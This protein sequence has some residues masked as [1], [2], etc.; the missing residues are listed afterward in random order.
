MATLID[1][2]LSGDLTTTHPIYPG[3]NNGGVG[4]QTSYYLYGNTSS[5]GIRTNGNFLV[6]GNIYFGWAGQWLSSW[7]NQNVRTDSSP[8]FVNVYATDWFR[9]YNTNGLYNQTYATHFYASSGTQWNIATGSNIYLALRTGHESTV[10]GYL[11]ANTD[12]NSGLLSSDGSW[13]VRVNNSEVELYHVTYADDF[14]PNIIYDRNNTSYY[15]N[16]DGTSNLWKLYVNAKYSLFGS[17]SNWDSGSLNGTNDTIT[18]V[19]FQGHTDFWIGAGNTKW[20]TGVVSGHHDLLINTMQSSGSNTRGITFTASLSG[21]SVYRLGRWFANTTQATSYLQVDGSIKIGATSDYYS[22]PVAK[23]H[24]TGATSGADVLAIDGVN[25]RLFTVTD[26]LS[27][28]LF[29]VNTVAGLPVMEVFADNSIVLG[30]FGVSD[31]GTTYAN[32]TI[33]VK[34]KEN[35]YGISIIGDYMAGMSFYANKDDG[36]YASQNARLGW[37]GIY[38]GNLWF[39]SAAPAQYSAPQHYFDGPVYAS[40]IYDSND[41]GYYVNPNSTSRLGTVNANELRSYGNT[42][43]G[44][45]S[46]DETHINDIVR[47]GATDSG[48]AHLFFGEGGAAGSDYGAHWYW[49]SGYTFTWNTRN[50]GSDTALFTYVT[51]DTTYV[52]WFRHFNMGGKELN[53]V[54]QVHF[55]SDGPIL[56]RNNS[57]NLVVKGGTS[58]DVGIVGLDASG[59][60]RFQ[61]YG[62]GNDYGFLDGTW[63][64]WDLRKVKDGNLYMNDNNTYYLNTSSTSYLYQLSVNQ[65]LYLDN[66]YGSSIVGLY[67]SY[68]YQGVFAMGNSYKLALD[69]TSPGSLYGLAWTHTNVGGESK[70]GLSHQLLIMHNGSTQTAIGTGIWT[71]GTITTTS[72]GTSANWNTAYGWGNHASAGYA[73]SGHNHDGSYLPIGGKAADSNLLDGLDLHTGRNNEAN[74]VVRTDSDGYI[75]AGW[76][77]TTSGNASTGTPDKFFGSNDN[78]IRYYDRAY[79]QMY[80]GNTYKYTTSRRQHTTDANYW[81]GTMGWGTTDWN[82]IIDWGSGFVESWSN[83]GNQPASG[84]S[85]HTGLQ[86]VHYTNGASRY[87]WQMVNAPTNGEL[88]FRSIWG[89]SFTGW[90]TVIHSS[91]IGSQSVSY[92]STSGTANTANSVSWGNVTGKPSTFTP[93]SHTHSPTEVGLGNVT[94]DAQV[95]TT[96]NTS[97]NSDT[98]NSRGV[99]RLYRYDDNSD[100]SLQ[101]YWTGSYW[102]LRGF[103]GDTYHAGVQ[104]AYADS[105]GSASSATNATTAGQVA[106]NYNNDSN[107]TYQMLWGSGNSVYGTGGIYCNP[108]SDKIFATAFSDTDTSYYLDPNSYSNLYTARAY[109]WQLHAGAGYGV[110]FWGGSGSYSIQMSEA[111]NGS[112]G[113][114]VGGETTSDYNMYF[115]MT[116]GTNRGFVFRNSISSSGAVAGIDG[117]GNFRA[118]GDAIVYASSDA[119]LK[120][121]VKPIENALDKVMQ[122]RGVEFDWNNNQDVYTGHD[123]GVIA[124]EVEAVLP[125]IVTTRDTGY[126]AVK[127]EKLTALLIE[128]VKELKAEIEELKAQ[129]NSK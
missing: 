72:H 87:G 127:Y 28:S 27:D 19:H 105:A 23:L 12:N 103:N 38:Q 6:D 79:T 35:D 89:S 14:R 122:L 65:N 2:S 64:A 32:G 107:S 99:T 24:V 18:N 50:A 31:P 10:R 25:G 43:L 81:T 1:L 30:K 59:N 39:Q 68:R 29:S 52:N 55:N 34:A 7:V 116:G 22:T 46:G 100:F 61:L 75:Q 42:Y 40:I 71:S 9:T 123:I 111:G 91:N 83:P 37:I 78:Y 86:V 98:R 88:Y 70:A 77:N 47:I 124:Q 63:A 114:R 56:Q 85:H 104:V 62:A 69:G 125:E 106:I 95:R 82:S 128:T 92:A 119:R 15:L 49:D 76:I 121:N 57:R 36:Y 93:S 118:K 54:G 67:D 21:G 101:H 3:Y 117:N 5:S 26:D 60:N 58:S 94:N 53:Y 96:Y 115:T 16:L 13:S 84:D 17:S 129:L 74:K 44:D 90:K 45:G 110:R 80:L 113:G 8:T 112:W 120:D 11:H 33:K 51:N 4:T 126:K 109:E 20:Y 41:N 102:H 66:N 97:L 48:D 73:A 108:N